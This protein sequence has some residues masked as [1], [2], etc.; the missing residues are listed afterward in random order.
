MV[1]LGQHGF[2]HVEHAA[3]EVL[4]LLRIVEK[5]GAKTWDAKKWKTSGSKTQDHCGAA[6]MSHGVLHLAP[7]SA[8]VVLPLAHNNGG[9]HPVKVH[10]A[11]HQT[12][13]KL[14][15]SMYQA[16]YSKQS[17]MLSGDTRDAQ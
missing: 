8:T 10:K 9:L 2:D 7:F 17:V 4:V 5:A 3:V 13:V 12:C 15:V 6:V 16:S 11:R 1:R 14:Y